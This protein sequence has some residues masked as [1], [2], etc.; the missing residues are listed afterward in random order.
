MYIQ[1]LWFGRETNISERISK[2]VELKNERYY[3]ELLNYYNKNKKIKITAKL[4]IF[5]RI[6]ILIDKAGLKR[7]LLINPVSIILLSFFTLGVSYLV[8]FKI[9]RIIFLSFIISLPS[10]FLPVYILTLMTEYNSWK[11]EKT[12]QDFLLQLKNYTQINNDIV[13]AFKQV[14]TMEPLQGYI[15]TFLL[16]LGS[17]IKFEKAIEN[18]KEK[19]SFETLKAVFSNISYCY[20]YGGDFAELMNKSYKTINRIQKEKASRNEETKNARI[21]LRNFNLSRF[22]YIF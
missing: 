20:L 6:N 3:K 11:L 5:Y 9:F 14:K 4:N 16:E 10:I 18:I 1:L 22:V 7:G 15:N 21:V 19:I 17:G 8:V 12:M 13:Y 2:Y